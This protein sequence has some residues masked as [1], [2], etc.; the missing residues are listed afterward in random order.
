MNIISGRIAA[1][2]I[3]QALSIVLG[4]AL[5]GC[6]TNA[7]ESTPATDEAD[8]HAA[9][10]GVKWSTFQGISIPT[11][12]QG[13]KRTDGVVA[14]GFAHTPAGA[15]LAGIQATIRISVATDTQWAR[16]GQQMLIAGPGRDAWATNRVQ[17]S[18][19]TPVTTGAPKILG[20]QITSYTPDRAEVAI[21]AIHPDSSLTRNLASLVWQSEDWRL[22]LPERPHTSPVAA[23]A[24][25]PADMVALPA[26]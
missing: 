24:T 19:A 20:Y 10:T 18:I 12:D 16:I 8:V 3:T 22:L 9:P 6:G 13:P 5:L 7:P 1:T 25:P 14:A 26:K 23:I 4:F 21:Y 2:L 17:I 15:A 11:A